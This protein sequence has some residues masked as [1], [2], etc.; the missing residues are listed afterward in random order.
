MA[1]D[2]ASYRNMVNLLEPQLEPALAQAEGV[3]REEHINLSIAI[4]LRRIADSLEEYVI[5]EQE[6]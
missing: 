4:S 5:V 6:R 2:Y 3:I 1:S